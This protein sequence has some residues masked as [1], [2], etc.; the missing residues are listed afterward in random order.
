[1][2]AAHSLSVTK[3][4]HL[5]WGDAGIRD[6]FAKVFRLL[7]PGGRFILEPQAYATYYRRSRLNEVR[8][9]A[10]AARTHLGPSYAP[11]IRGRERS[12]R[13]QTIKDNYAHIELRPE[14]FAR[15][16][17]D[18]VGFESVAELGTPDHAS[19]RRASRST[20]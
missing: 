1:M 9:A 13:P 12:P 15:Y 16:L 14:A 11:F 6:L 2:D 20:S 7:K 18:T 10:A 5:N 8:F 3:W 19:S 4:V 17:L